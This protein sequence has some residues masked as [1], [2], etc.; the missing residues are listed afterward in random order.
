MVKSFK[1]KHKLS[2]DNGSSLGVAS[3]QLPPSNTILLLRL[4]QIIKHSVLAFAGAPSDWHKVVLEWHNS[5]RLVKN[6]ITVSGTILLAQ[7]S[8]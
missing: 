2:I 6:S 7:N 1:F 8:I 5:I 3:M 4:L